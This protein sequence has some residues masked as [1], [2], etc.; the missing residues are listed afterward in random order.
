MD[1]ELKNVG[2]S[3]RF[4]LLAIK[5][6]KDQNENKG[7]IECPKCKGELHFTRAFSNGHI[8][9]KCKTENCLSWAT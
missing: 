7:I 2:S 8:W 3:F 9:G 5:T 6:I 4:T 1:S